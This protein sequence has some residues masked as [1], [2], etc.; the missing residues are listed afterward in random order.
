MYF[1][2]RS[3]NQNFVTDAPSLEDALVRAFGQCFNGSVEVIQCPEKIAS[4]HETREILYG[5][6]IFASP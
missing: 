5:N 2:F 4:T 3:N 1:L 6:G